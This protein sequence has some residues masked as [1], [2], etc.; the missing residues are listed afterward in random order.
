[1]AKVVGI[2]LQTTNSVVSVIEG[3]EPTLSQTPKAADSPPP[4]S[5]SRK[6]VSASSGRCQA[7][8]RRQP[9]SHH[10]SPSSARWEPTTRCPID[11]KVHA[12]E[13][14]AM[15][16]RKLKNDAEPISVSL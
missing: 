5:A 13:I 16:L 10:R 4:W 3:G 14:S 7:P 15:I 6:L 12:A 8:G 11:G 9:R 1:M 2:D